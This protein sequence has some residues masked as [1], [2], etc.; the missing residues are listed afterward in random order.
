MKL[1]MLRKSDRRLDDLLEIIEAEIA[2]DLSIAGLAER[3]HLSTSRLAHLFRDAMGMPLHAYVRSRRLARASS[4]L[5]A[6]D[7]RVKQIAILVGFQDSRHF[8]AVFERFT[9]LTPSAF[10]KNG[11]NPPQIW[12]DHPVLWS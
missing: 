11:R 3:L 8:A 5:L 7:L 4:L 2:G 1:S 9:G 12:I 6:S 10:R